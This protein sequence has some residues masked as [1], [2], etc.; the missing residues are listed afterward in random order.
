[1]FWVE[2]ICRLLM[3]ECIWILLGVS[4]FTETL[5]VFSNICATK[6]DKEILNKLQ[7][8]KKCRKK[9][10]DYVERSHTARLIR[11]EKIKS[12]W[13]H[14]VQLDQSPFCLRP[15]L[16][17]LCFLSGEDQKCHKGS[18]HK[19]HQQQTVKTCTSV[20][21]VPGLE[22]CPHVPIWSPLLQSLKH[23]SWRHSHNHMTGT[24]SESRRDNI[25]QFACMH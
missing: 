7:K 4:R 24:A 16:S 3:S 10:H 20:F 9:K 18:P 14:L 5:Q 13:G 17:L 22:F 11:G 23:K 1:M 2:Q 6:G 8:H 15:G 25:C 21:C 12:Q 19:K